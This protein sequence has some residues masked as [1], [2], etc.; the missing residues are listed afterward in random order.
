VNAR[1]AR[2]TSAIRAAGF[3]ASALRHGVAGSITK[4][5]S[6]GAVVGWSAR[7]VHF[8]TAEYDGRR[9][10]AVQ[11][12]VL[13]AGIVAQAI[14]DLAGADVLYAGVAVGIERFGAAEVEIGA[15]AVYAAASV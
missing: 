14:L 11:A 2:A 7:F 6:R 12:S 5:A 4:A 13:G 8:A 15:V 9:A 3:T 1:A 10:G